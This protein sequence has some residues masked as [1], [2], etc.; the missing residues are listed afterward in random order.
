MIRAKLEGVLSSLGPVTI[1]VSGG[2]DSMTLA[3]VANRL[4]GA[5][6]V[7]VGHAVSPAVQPEAT[8]RVRLWADREGWALLTLDAGEFGDRNYLD[9]PVNRCFFCKGH[10]Y[11][12]IA[13]VSE[14]QILSGANMDD[15]GEYR[16]GL[17]AAREVG[18][19]HPYVE[20]EIDKASIRALAR[21]LGLGD[22][23]ELPASP[24]LSSRVETAIAIEPAMLIAIH[25]VE[26][27]VGARLQPQTV[28]CRVRHTGVVV[29][30]DQPALAAADGD[31][32][33]RA[34]ITALLP[35]T[36][37]ARPVRFEAYRK[38][39]AFVGATS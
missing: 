2:V 13:R 35:G 25:A 27:L 16:P 6:T 36:L 4:L 3:I 26:K 10:L 11:G 22:L 37:A 39:S 30:L 24:C 8:E 32:E 23:A 19:R 31:R 15:L 5:D 17:D 28:R 20:A 34:A 12:A 18:V 1:A 33:L 38:G 9:N 7:N 14:R 21:E 29:E